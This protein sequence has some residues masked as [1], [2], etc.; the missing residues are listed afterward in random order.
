MIFGLP[1][2]DVVVICLYF[3][4]V[5]AI[6]V[7]S[8]RRV[9]SQVDFF[10]AGKRFGKVVQTF[11][12]FGMGTNTD[13]SVNVSTNVFVNGSSGVWSSLSIIFTTPFYWLMAPWYQRLRMLTLGDFFIERYGSRKMA[14]L[15]AVL[16]SI[17]LMAIVALGFS[18]MG[19][20]VLGLTP[21]PL[22]ELSIEEKAEYERA[23]KLSALEGEDFAQLRDTEKDRLQALRLEQPRQSHSYLNETLLVYL[24]CLVVLLYGAAGG[25]QAAFLTDMFQGIFLIILS[26]LLLPFAVI[27]VNAV[28]GGDGVL[29]AFN[30][31]HTYLP[32]SAL[33]LWGSPQAIDWNWYFL[34]SVCFIQTLNVAIQPNMLTAIGA[35]RDEYTGR[36]GYV[37]GVLI[38]R[39]VT[40]LWGVFSLFALLLYMDEISN[41]DLVWG[42]ATLDLLGALNLGLVGL[43]IACLL[44]ALMSTADVLMITASSLFTHNLYKEFV[45]GK[46][47]S[48]YL[49]V[50]RVF[51][52]VF[53]FGAG[54]LALGFNSILTLLK[55]VWGFFAVFAAT[56]WL[57]MLWRRA[58]KNAA[59]ASILTT[60]ILF[61]VIPAFL[62]ILFPGMRTNEALLISTP[63]RVV[64][65]VYTATE[66]DLRPQTAS[67]GEAIAVGQTFSKTFEISGRSV[68]W[69]QGIIL[70]EEGRKA[71][72]G[73]FN[74][75]LWILY[76]LG[77]PVESFVYA[78]NE[79]I[80]FF[81]RMIIPFGILFAF[82]LLRK[83]EASPELDTFYVK[84]RT[85]VTQDKEQD[86]IQ[87][88]QGISNPEQTRNLKLFPDSD[89]E[90]LRWR[91]VSYLGF[92][93]TCGITVVLLVVATILM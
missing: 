80:K 91:R 16:G 37:A 50:G 24:T 6:G 76:H 33:E 82:S 2:L 25:L 5:L 21:K 60:A 15:Y 44:S 62:P 83:P 38:K 92:F 28:Y 14:M 8:A 77:I 27:K 79:S 13:T 30:S 35:A 17:G 71:G 88:Q 1:L 84:L 26:I 46:S 89:W 73:L 68:F 55:F 39:V 18:A 23:V 36:F 74:L 93:A 90:I 34:V 29:D 75:D 3:G 7:Y 51:G 41:P 10:L 20:T 87:L 42:Y 49:M 19:K 53:I 63:N 52:I 78:F 48:H 45:P 31:L 67:E 64:E 70:D 47:E 11:A 86:V 85:P 69:D 32:E 54:A 56:F 81:L 58:S 61:L 40:V 12:A 4:G 22:A 43:M 66:A 72:K 59:W 9:R 57:G 65:R